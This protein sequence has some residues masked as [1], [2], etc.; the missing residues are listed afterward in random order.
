MEGG[1]T[2][3][4]CNFSAWHNPDP[5]TLL[6]STH[7]PWKCQSSVITPSSFDDGELAGTEDTNGMGG[8]AGME[9]EEEEEEEEE[10][11]EEL[12]GGS[13][14]AKSRCSIRFQ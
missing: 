8:T 6:P 5:H 12:P 13:T 4:N 9:A 3:N 11:D 1:K 10:A 7:P 2:A 14:G